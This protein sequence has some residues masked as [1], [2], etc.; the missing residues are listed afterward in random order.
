MR[1]KFLEFLYNGGDSLPE[2]LGCFAGFWFLCLGVF[3]EVIEDEEGIT[4][5]E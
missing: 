1:P 2:W 3:I 5:E 4:E